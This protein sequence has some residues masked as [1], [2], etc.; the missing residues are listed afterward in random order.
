MRDRDAIDSELRRLAAM[1]RSIGKHGGEPLSRQVDKLLD[2]RL[3]HHAEA[4]ETEAVGACPAEVV[5]DTRSQRDGTDAARPYR[6][7]VV[8]R[9]FGLLAAL[10]L[11]LMAVAAAVVVMFAVHKPDSV[12]QPSPVPPSGA[13]PNPVP[14]AARPNPAA[15]KAPA[16]QLDLVDRAFIDTLKR[17]GVPIP[18]HEY[19]LTQGHAVCD[20][21]AQQPRFADA[22]DFVQRSSMWDADQ[23]TELAAGAIVSYCPQYE[24]A[25]SDEMQQTFQNALSRLQA[26]QD[27]M[28][29][30]RDGLQ[31]LPG[32][33]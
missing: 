7:K 17:Q 24:L 9:R 10:P 32:Q 13:R 28:Q 29:G 30:I 6:P 19:A 12:A 1:R 14:S 4:S 3:G 20:F 5:A 31:A 11:S 33:H 8:P 2:E 27:E 23:S 25:G 26:I 22:V 21:L 18:S 16:P 15:P